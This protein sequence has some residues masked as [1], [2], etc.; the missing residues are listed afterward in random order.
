M[1]ESRRPEGEL[2][3]GWTTGA[4]ATA[5]AR[6]AYEALVTGRFPDPVTIRLPQGQRPSFALAKAEL[7]DGAATAG[8]VKDA[9]DDPDVTHGAMVLA[10]LRW[11]GRGGGV[12]FRAGDGV[13]TITRPG[14]P[15]GVGEPAINP[16]PRAMMR[17]AIA[18]AAEALGGAA[19]VEITV[20]I[21]GG[22]ALAARTMNGRLGIVGGL[23]IL[24]TTGV[25]IPY[26]CSSWIHSIHRGVDVARAAGITHL[27]GATGS[28]SE[29]AAQA[30]FQAPE[31]ALIDMGD[32]VGGLLKYLR[33][34]P[35]PRLTIAGG[36]AKLVKLAQ[37][38]L[39]LHSSRSS[40]DLSDLAARVAR[41]GGDAALVREASQAVGAGTGAVLALASAHDL[42]L[43]DAIARGAREVVQAALAGD[44]IVDVQVFD[45]AGQLIGHAGP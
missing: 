36:F 26:S 45:R 40:V 20:S 9:G 34:H 43:G 27:I 5:A 33:K 38:H 18:D 39:D 2:K 30:M 42:K 6:A 29:R 7:G 17:E 21:P 16:G 11:G 8:V 1:S 12:T 22:Q 25:V 24:G 19:D 41:L 44:T 3:R 32:F 23:S 4:C 35:V 10:T 14:L 15:L 13:G 37:G 31:Q 28:T